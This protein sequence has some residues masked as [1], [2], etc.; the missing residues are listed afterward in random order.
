MKLDLYVDNVQIGAD[1]DVD[2]T[3]GKSHLTVEQIGAG[4]NVE[5]DGTGELLAGGKPAIT[6]GGS[7]NLNMGSNIGNVDNELVV[8]TDGEVVW[9]TTYG[10]GHVNV[11][12]SSGSSEQMDRL[13]DDPDSRE[14]YVR[15]EDG[16]LERNVRP[17]T[18]LEVFGYDLQNAFLWV[19]TEQLRKTLFAEAQ[20]QFSLKITVNGEIVF[21]Y[22]VAIDRIVERIL[23][24]GKLIPVIEWD[25]DGTYSENVL[26]FQYYV[27]HEYDGYRYTVS[28]VCDGTATEITGTVVD[29]CIVFQTVNQI[30]NVTVDVFAE[31]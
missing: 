28:V 29:G 27:G 1:G 3:S 17:G 18:G 24:D 14:Y 8:K 22:W 5:I 6:A 25:K 12:R 30:S 16:S 15:K 10:T 11:I 21:D 20:N 2:L 9:N 4:G 13:W 23:T 7:V 31:V 26:T 19:G